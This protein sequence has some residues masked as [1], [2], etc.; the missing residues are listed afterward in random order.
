MTILF[1]SLTC[2]GLDLYDFK[3]HQ[4]SSIA[5]DGYHKHKTYSSVDCLAIISNVI[6][7]K[8]YNETLFESIK[9]EFQED[10]RYKYGRGSYDNLTIYP[11]KY[12][13]Q[14]YY[15]LVGYLVLSRKL[16]SEDNTDI[17]AIT[18]TLIQHFQDYL[19]DFKL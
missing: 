16:K 8:G 14:S 2:F 4:I 6:K 10:K 13:W 3:K 11:E 19:R 18:I 7:S 9:K 1:I 17:G 15:E 5:S 12:L